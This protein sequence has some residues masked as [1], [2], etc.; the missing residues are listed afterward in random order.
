MI[1]MKPTNRRPRGWTSCRY[2]R[3]VPTPALYPDPPLIASHALPADG[4]H[5]LQVQEFGAADG[6]PALVL[7]GGPGSGCS[8][9]LRRFFDPRRYRIICPDQR[10]TGLSRP[11]GGI[12]HNTTAELIA[13]LRRIRRHLGIERWL[14]TGGSW[15]ATLAVAY[16]AA[17]PD[18]I[19]ALLL[20]ASFLARSQ[21]IAGFFA[22]LSL[23]ALATALSSPQASEREGAALAWWQ[24][25]QSLAGTAA[26]TVAPAGEALAFQVDRLRVQ[27]HYLRHGCWLQAP[28]LLERC[29]AV[30][31]VPILLI[32]ARD[33]RICRAE[34]AIEL[35]RRLPHAGLRWVEE[36]GH[37]AAHPAMVAATVA[38]LDR[39]AAHGDFEVAA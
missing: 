38:A 5:V 27:A 17:E 24:H 18:A 3:R 32:H 16:A 22:G 21:D 10:G 6:L 19:A 15:G 28:T 23:D 7:H 39:F 31:R 2:H 35:Q 13:D 37:D 33:D 14:V 11:R 4:G 29:E 1:F 36:G 34:G 12:E 8:P 9:L 26:S 30:P 20:R 25:E